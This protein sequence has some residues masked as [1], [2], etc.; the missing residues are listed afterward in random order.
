MGFMGFMRVYERGY[1]DQLLSLAWRFE[2]LFIPK[3][4]MNKLPAFFVWGRGAS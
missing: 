2:L 4:F 3:I 1:H